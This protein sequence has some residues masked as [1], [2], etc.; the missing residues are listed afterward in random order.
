MEKQAKNVLRYYVLCNRL[1]NV[2]R[3]GWT[4]WHVHKDRV[5]S[6]AEHIFGVQMMALAM[7]SEYEYDIDIL[8]VI[9]MLAVHELEE[10]VIG[11]LTMF[12]IDAK[13]KE[14]MGHQAI[15]KVLQGL[16]KKD[17]I[18]DIILEFD[19]RQTKEA[20]FAYHCDKLECDIQSK[21]YDEEG[22]VDLNDQEGNKTVD[23][24]EVK[25]L[26]E[27]GKTWSE[28]WLE[29]GRGRYNYDEHFTEVSKYAETHE[30]K[31]GI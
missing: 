4:D 26:L 14:E 18:K 30:V 23:N 17:E 6:V 25:K 3:T 2:I 16:V 29:F 21:L 27:S 22:C 13:T 11:D 10:I 20:D 1:K 19:A 9:L 8:H 15:E 28:M 24:P 12:Q 31:K 7:Y 5:E